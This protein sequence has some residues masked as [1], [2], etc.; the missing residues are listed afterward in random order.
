MSPAASC[1]DPGGKLIGLRSLAG[2][3]VRHARLQGGVLEGIRHPT[4]DRVAQWV[5]RRS[6]IDGGLGSIPGSVHNFHYA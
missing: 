1:A 4:I 2:W 5:E 3:S 6:R